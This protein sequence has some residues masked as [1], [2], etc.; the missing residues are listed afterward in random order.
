M[1]L[2]FWRR[3]KKITHEDA[4]D[5]PADELPVTS[6][7]QNLPPAHSNGAHVAEAAPLRR[8]YALALQDESAAAPHANLDSTQSNLLLGASREIARIGTEQRYTPRRPAL[9][10]QLL[11][12]VND[13]EASLR[14]LARIVAQ[15]LELTGELL[16][17]ANSAFYRVNDTPVE[18]VERAAAILGTQGIRGI[19][20]ASLVQP[21]AAT[22][23]HGLGRFG[24]LV[25]EHSLYC[26]SAAEAWAAR[27]QQADPFTAHLLGLMHGL[28]AVAV[29]RVLTDV[30]KHAHKTLD[31]VAAVSALETSAAISASR[32]AG[33][34]G[35]SEK[36]REALE[37]Q[38]L[39]AP[40][41]EH[42]PLAQAL[43]FGL[44]LG[45]LTLLCKYEQRA[46]DSVLPQLAAAGFSGPNAERVWERML[47]AYVQP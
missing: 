34:W 40:V 35:L 28:G 30:A 15:D 22:D 4:H 37:A 33:N 18:N 7:A 20:A 31:A 32:I 10:P 16:R 12:A 29:M 36:T 13:E 21:L 23:E 6:E 42:N 5:L 19:I 24:E 2:F 44:L 9:L 25:W 41:N 1:F 39:A 17:T 43:Q 45:S 3:R 8:V 14:S 46:P 11:E 26:G 47:R 27:T 38:S